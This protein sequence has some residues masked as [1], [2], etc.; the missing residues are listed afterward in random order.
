MIYF[1][2]FWLFLNSSRHAISTCI[3]QISHVKW[4]SHVWIGLRINVLQYKCVHWS[5]FL[6]TDKRS[7]AFLILR[8]VYDITGKTVRLWRNRSITARTGMVHVTDAFSSPFLGVLD[9]PK[10]VRRGR[11]PFPSGSDTCTQLY[12]GKEEAVVVDSYD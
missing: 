6:H 11:W 10:D 9:P 5:S 8:S 4:F 12:D 3:V 7:R 2:D 1:T